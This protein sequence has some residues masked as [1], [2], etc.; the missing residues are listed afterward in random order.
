[1]KFWHISFSLHLRW[2][3]VLE[4]RNDKAYGRCHIESIVE[5]I[6]YPAHHFPFFYS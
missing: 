4:R 5:T 2:L 3:G 6:L 1:M